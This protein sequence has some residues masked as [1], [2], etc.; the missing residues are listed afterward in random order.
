VGVRYSEITEG[1]GRAAEGRV[2]N[3]VKIADAQ[4]RTTFGKRKASI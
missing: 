3:A 2:W 1:G 4:R